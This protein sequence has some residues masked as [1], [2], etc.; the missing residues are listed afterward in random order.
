MGILSQAPNLNI[1]PRHE[2]LKLSWRWT[3]S[4]SRGKV[5]FMKCNDAR[6][7]NSKFQKGT[8]R[9]CRWEKVFLSTD[10][11][12][13]TGQTNRGSLPTIPVGRGYGRPQFKRISAWR[14][15]FG[16]LIESTLLPRRDGNVAPA[17]LGNN[18]GLGRSHTEHTQTHTLMSFGFGSASAL[19]P[20]S[21]P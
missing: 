14:G 8:S 21:W 3:T 13:E 1:T 11:T 4:I 15:N 17:T 16:E 12:T 20:V 19:V 9:V 2:R 18:P 10:T 7:E 6:G 5:T